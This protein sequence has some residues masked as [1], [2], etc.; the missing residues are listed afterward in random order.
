MMTIKPGFF[1]RFPQLRDLNLSNNKLRNISDGVF[2]QAL[3]ES[4]SSLDLSYKHIEDLHIE[5]LLQN[6]TYVFKVT[7]FSKLFKFLDTSNLSVL[8]ETL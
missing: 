3:G 7:Y 5:K 1:D 8:L 2:S 4:L 6:L